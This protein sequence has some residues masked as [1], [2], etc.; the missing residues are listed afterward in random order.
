MYLL[1]EIKVIILMINLSIHLI[2]RILIKDPSVVEHPKTKLSSH[3]TLNK[4][5]NNNYQLN[6][7]LKKPQ[8]KQTKTP[9]KHQL[10]NN[11]LIHPSVPLFH[12]MKY[13]LEELQL[14]K[15]NLIKFPLVK[16]TTHLQCHNSLKVM[17]NLLHKLTIQ[18]LK[19]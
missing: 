11:L 15:A 3:N 5:N 8:K 9:I 13:Q 12:W 19:N 7:P 4:D 17:I 18:C 6:L 2:H 10:P 1:E 14:I 16:L